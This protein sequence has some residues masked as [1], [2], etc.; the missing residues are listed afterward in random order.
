VGDWHLFF[1][2]GS[3]ESCG[4]SSL[5][6]INPTSGVGALVASLTLEPPDDVRA[7]AFSPGGTLYASIGQCYTDLDDE[8]H[9]INPAS[10]VTTYVGTMVEAVQALDFSDATG[11]LYGWD[12]TNGLITIDPA[13]GAVSDV[14][15][16]VVGEFIQSLVVRPD[17]SMLGA[18]TTAL[19]S[20]DSVTGNQ[21]LIGSNGMTS[22]RGIELIDDP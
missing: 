10:G 22:V 19:Y 16:A 5:I 13:T 1:S 4:L 11:V 2:A 9:I 12:L 20:I 7:I 6:T 15:P 17:G 8:L 14:N 3:D 18:S 21:T